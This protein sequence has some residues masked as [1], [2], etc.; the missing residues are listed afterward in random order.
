[1]GQGIATGVL[2]GRRHFIERARLTRLLDECVAD[3]IVVAAPAGYGKTT[4]AKEWLSK[5]DGA[6]GWYACSAASSDVAALT[7]GVAAALI[8]DAATLDRVRH[9]LRHTRN[10]DT[11]I[12]GL[13]AMLIH[14]DVRRPGK[15]RIVI[16]DYQQLDGAHAAEE[17]VDRLVFES[18][19]QWLITTRFRPRWATARRLLYGEVQEIGAAVL[20]LTNEEAL[21]V[22]TVNGGDPERASG[23][24]ALAQG[25]PAVI[26]LAA[27]SGAPDPPQGAVPEAL[28][29]Y[30][31]EE[32][33][34]SAQ[35]RLRDHLPTLALIPPTSTDLTAHLVDDVKA[36]LT[37]A[38]RIGFITVLTDQAY[39]MH[40]LLRSFL[41]RKAN[42]SPDYQSRL[43]EIVTVLA[44]HA[45][46][47]DAFTV[48]DHSREFSLL[49]HVLGDSLDDLLA[50]GRV[51]T[52]ERW[53]HRSHAERIDSPEVDMADAE[54]ALRRG[55]YLRAEALGV[56]VAN[57]AATSLAVRALICAGRSA[58]FADRYENARE[59]F[60]SASKHAGKPSDQREAAWGEMLATHQIAP[61]GART[62]LERFIALA[63]DSPESSLRVFIGR[64]HLASAIGPLEPLV[65]DGRALVPIAER[66]RDPY[67]RTS[68]FDSLC[69][70]FALTAYYAEARA[71]TDLELREAKRYALRFVLPAALC[72]RA[73]ADLGLRRFAQAW[74]EAN[75]ADALAHEMADVHSIYQAAVIR[76]RIALARGNPE[77]ALK[78]LGEI[79]QR[80][81][82]AGMWIEFRVFRALAMA[83]AGS[84]GLSLTEIPGIRTSG[85]VEARV[86]AAATATILSLDRGQPIEAE[87]DYLEDEVRATGC[88]DVLVTAYRAR[89]AL[90]KELASRK[91]PFLTNLVGKAQDYALAQSVGFT[92]PGPQQRRDLTPRE[93]Q[94]LALI[95]EGK[96]NREI[97][98]LLVITEATAKLHVRHVL[99]KLGV[100]SRT[101]AALHAHAHDDV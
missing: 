42:E 65:A 15:S 82:G 79:D 14:P 26:G 20:A 33:L 99:E 27:H 30:F 86:A 12:E 81:P 87:L 23:L 51:S 41:A 53:L 80:R 40:P 71:M 54:V 95:A 1:M 35:P 67:V 90:L 43:R 19:D 85:S 57:S 94:V 10:P 50:D 69:R 91:L 11:D 46:W 55:D 17:F 36:L 75:E 72:G 47:D 63:D 9:R 98:E 2:P 48:I 49:S 64:Y 6:T 83:C 38:Q 28:Y 7:H 52:V 29:D 24:V 22:I 16:D 62:L 59:H 88:Y 39:E 66:A 44:A 101:E 70:V 97:A 77:D 3:V 8:D 100:R 32:L 96:S 61:G 21:E 93:T 4:L 45:R 56:R 25:W 5:G 73:L 31:A 74:S 78:W 92:V 13:I 58:H 18:G 37:E 60:A 76:A 89:P 84:Q 34:A 68:F